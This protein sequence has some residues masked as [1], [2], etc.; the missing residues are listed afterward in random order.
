MARFDRGGSDTLGLWPWS[1]SRLC[2]VDSGCSNALL[3]VPLVYASQDPA[4][5]LR[6]AKLCLTHG[7]QGQHHGYENLT[8][9]VPSV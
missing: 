6:M 4:P 1:A 9:M 7:V 3:A 5:R 2:G 8:P